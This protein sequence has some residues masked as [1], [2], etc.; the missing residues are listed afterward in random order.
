MRAST[1]EYEKDRRRN[2]IA[3][4][5]NAPDS[6]PWLRF[7]KFGVEVRTLESLALSPEVWQKGSRKVVESE[8]AES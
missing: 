8:A 1:G 7:Q 2:S 3:Y 4:I 6:K 5:P